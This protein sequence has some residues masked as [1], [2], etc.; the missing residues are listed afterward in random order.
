MRLNGGPAGNRTLDTKITSLVLYHLSSRPTQRRL[1]QGRLVRQ[2]GI[3]GGL[4][5][6]PARTRV[7]P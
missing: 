2:S 1:T 7:T 4:G 3:G 6:P 5:K